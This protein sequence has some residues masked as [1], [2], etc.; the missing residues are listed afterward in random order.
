MRF[1]H[2]FGRTLRQAPAEAETDSY[3]LVL[4]AALVRQVAAGLYSYLPLGWRVL[5][6]IEAIIREEMDRVDGQEIL[7]P[8]VNPA[9]LWKESGRW[10]AIGADLVRFTDR[11]DRDFVLA[12]THEEVVTDLTRHEVNSYRQLPYMLY[13][14]QT[15]VRDEPR[16]RGGLM[17]MREFVMKDA[18]SFHADAADLDEYY[19]RIYQSYLN[20]FRRCGLDP[21]PVEA[22]PGLIGGTGSHEFILPTGTGEDT[23]IR[24]TACGYAANVDK[25]I[26]VKTLPDEPSLAAVEPPELVYTPGIQTIEQLARFLNLP[27]T[28][29]LKSVFYVVDGQVVAVVIRGDLEVNEAKLAR[30]LQTIH[31]RFATDDE[32]RAAGVPA[33][34]ASPVGRQNLRVIADDSVPGRVFVAGANQPDY[35]LRNVLP[36]RDFVPEVVS[37]LAR[38]EHGQACA[39]CG[40]E[41]AAVR[42]I[43]LGHTFKL[44][45]KYSEP[46]GAT[47][48]A[49]DGKEHTIV[50]GCYGIGVDRL[51]GAI[52]E[53]CHDDAGIIWP[54]SIAPFQVH[55]V[56]LNLDNAEVARRAD[57]LY[58][59]LTDRGFEVLFDDRSESPGVKFADADLIGIPLRLTM[60]QRTLKSESVELKRR[61]EREFRLV[62][63][64]GLEDVLRQEI[65][66]PLH[67][68]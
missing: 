46:M 31:F 8:V 26:S 2:L 20:V 25:A 39:Q 17:R 5:R 14:I 32:L 54:R 42:G 27:S 53:V 1:S 18:Y 68:P 65:E 43:E 36:G 7:M 61:T 12:M 6:K 37:D 22:D 9:D 10:Y 15:K 13:Q 62:P 33:G 44:G 35:H 47:Y 60:S 11:A 59:Q 16:P 58:R 51:L 3:K 67:R 24:C 52:V 55:L 41:L 48:L 23:V 50:M 4:R 28:A 56:A 66:A 64:S 21:L 40:G 63:L 30:V 34:Y 49:A 45:T 19:P 38:A 57:H 29:M